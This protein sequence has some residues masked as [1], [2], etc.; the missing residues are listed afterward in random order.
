MTKIA[1][2]S[3]TNLIKYL[4]SRFIIIPS[5]A[6]RTFDCLIELFNVL[7]VKINDEE[8]PSCYSLL[9]L[10]LARAPLDALTLPAFISLDDLS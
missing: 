9:L 8:P 7:A 3:S 10:L 1:K 6:D 5:T 4:L 2:A